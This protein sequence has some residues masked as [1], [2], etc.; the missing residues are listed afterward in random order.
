MSDGDQSAVSPLGTL[1]ADAAEHRAR[2]SR[3]YREARNE[4][5]AIRELRKK[6]SIA[7]DL[8]ER[9]YELD[10]DPRF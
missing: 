4:Y 5:T 3:E 6:S 1:A 8:R 2:R 9:R 10:L 7:A